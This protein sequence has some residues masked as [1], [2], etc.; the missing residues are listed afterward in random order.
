MWHGLC[1]QKLASNLLYVIWLFLSCLHVLARSCI[2]LWDKVACFNFQMCFFTV[3]CFA[4]PGQIDEARKI[5]LRSI[6][7]LVSRNPFYPMPSSIPLDYFHHLVAREIP[8][9][10]FTIE[11]AEIVHD[12]CWYSLKSYHSK[13]ARYLYQLVCFIHF[14]FS[15]EDKFICIDSCP[16]CALSLTSQISNVVMTD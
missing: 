3:K 9:D 2:Y 4:Y 5:L 6:S 15:W 8:G 11:R 10:V 13:F 16:K 14:I 1:S 7:V 12:I